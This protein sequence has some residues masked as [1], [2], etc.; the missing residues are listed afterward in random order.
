MDC[1]LFAE[2]QTRGILPRLLTTARR[3]MDERKPCR[4]EASMAK[5][6]ASE[7]VVDLSRKV[8]QVLGGYRTR[9][10]ITASHQRPPVRH[11]RRRNIADQKLI[12][13]TKW[14][15]DEAHAK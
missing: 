12:I 6:F 9:W 7:L 2:M 11:H 3:L 13:A 5:L 15:F 1:D 8:M 14:D 4:K 10:S